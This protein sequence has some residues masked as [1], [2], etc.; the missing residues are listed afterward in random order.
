MRRRSR[1]GQVEDAVDLE[2]EGIDD[3]VAHELERGVRQKM[4]DVPLLA[5]EQVV[6]ADHL[7]TVPQ[8]PVAKVGAEETG[9]AGHEDAHG[10]TLRGRSGSG[11]QNPARGRGLS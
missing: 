10:K 2:L 6:D 7:V 5:G 3:V 1:A 11:Q 4:G 9:A 8:Q